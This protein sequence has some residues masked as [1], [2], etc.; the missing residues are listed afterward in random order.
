MPTYDTPERA[1]RA[2]LHIV[3]YRRNQQTLT[4][5]PP[6]VP[7]AFECDSIRARQI[8]E[9]VLKA[10]R[11]LL[12]EV[13]TKAVL[14]AYGI[15]VV[16]CRVATDPHAAQLAAAAIGR[17]VILK[18]MSRDLPLLTDFSAVAVDLRAPG[19]VRQAAE[20]MLM[21][22]RER[23]PK[24][25][26]EGFSVQPMAERTGVLEI[27]VGI[28]EDPEFGPVILFGSGGPAWDVIDD[29]VIA[30]PPLNMQLARD[31]ILRT[32]IA[33]L[34]Q[35]LR[36]TAIDD[37]AL[38]LTKV[39]QLVVDFAEV[40]SLTVNPLLVDEHGVIAVT[41]AMRVCR[42]ALPAAKRLAIRPYPKE[43]EE[44]LVLPDGRVLC[45]RPVLPEDEPAF[46]AL[47]ER[48]T[49]EDVRLR[50]FA[51]KKALTH[52]LAARMTQIDYDREMAL[53]L[54]EP[55]PPGRSL[56]FGAVH[57]TADPDNENAEYAI[58]LHSDMSGLGLGPMLMRQIIDYSRQ[59]GIK[60]IFGEVLRENRP[61]L[62]VCELFKFSRSIKPDDPG[63]IEVRLKL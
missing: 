38:T 50:F 46:Q 7:E 32:R 47:F 37:L 34:L 62:K 19:Q 39:S 54:A 29:T 45:L 31:A 44:T 2:F 51:P 55:G 56:I 6:S 59:R 25:R 49:P 8:I 33:G 1:V 57:I 60:E 40:A 10:G 43:L 42:A 41:A 53:V 22:L 26:V 4:E 61:M 3:T 23:L 30:L 14:E 15:A 58:M 28:T 16:P 18:I 17:P 9:A 24:A 36:G 63:T 48:L 13:E 35:G 11:H 20:R 5:T 52:P 27:L 21:L 12:T